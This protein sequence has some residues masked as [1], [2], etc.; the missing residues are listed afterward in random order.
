[1]HDRVKQLADIGDV[2]GLK[3]IFV[4]A[5]DVDPTFE[6]YQE[7]YAYCRSKGRFEPYQELT[8]LTHDQKEWT[9]D[10]WVQLKTD[11]LKNFSE[12]RLM[13]MKEVAQELKA[14][15]IRR[16]TEERRLRKEESEKKAAAEIKRTNAA[17]TQSSASEKLRETGKVGDKQKEENARV[18]ALKREYSSPT[19][20][21]PDTRVTDNGSVI[22]SHTTYPSYNKSKE[23][24]K[25]AFPVAIAAV[26]LAIIAIL[27]V[28]LVVAS[29]PGNAAE[30]LYMK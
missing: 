3:Y 28:V 6:L 16:L 30:L 7:D 9:M 2:K 10:Y 17:P 1:M 23:P 22:H 19:N 18:E 25:K 24:P 15:K 8:P 13:H 12:K 4:D 5:L 20:M 29:N 14:N 11:L 27:A 26:V 21:V